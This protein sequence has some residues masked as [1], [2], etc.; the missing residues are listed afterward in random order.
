MFSLVLGLAAVVGYGSRSVAQLPTIEPTL[1]EAPETT[2]GLPE[3]T[4]ESPPTVPETSTTS[5]ELPVPASP[6]LPAPGSP[7]LP[8][9]AYL[10][11][12]GDTIRIDILG[13][14][15][16]SGDY[17]IPIDGRLILPLVGSISV[18]GLT[19]EEAADAISKAY[20]NILK[21]P[22]ISVNL[23]A[24]RPL[25]IWIAGEINRPGSYAVSLIGG[26]G[27]R[28][29]TQYPTVTQVIEQAGGIKLTADLRRIELRRPQ[30]DGSQRTININLWEMLQTGDPRRGDI[31]LL[32]GDSIFIPTA[33]TVNLAE[34]RQLANTS[35]A[36]PIDQARNVTV[37]GEVARPGPYIVLGG[38][39]GADFNVGGLPTVT[40]AIQIA[41]GIKP[42]ANLREIQLRRPTRGGATEIISVNLWQ[43]LQTGDIN[44]DPIVQDGDII[45]VPATTEVNP[46]EA[47][48]IATASFAPDTIE[49]T[50]VGE[51][52][53]PGRIRVPPNSPL[54]QALSV[55]GGFR[56]DRAKQDSVELVRF[57][58]DG[59]VAQQ[60][61]PVDLAA[62]I[63]SQSNPMLRNNDIVVVNPSG[64]VKFNNS[65]NNAL[66]FTDNTNRLLT[67]LGFL[68]ILQYLQ[69]P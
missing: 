30:R 9:S 67:V 21:R 11:G 17:Q 27:Q 36:I 28:P 61:I 50:V 48:Q 66:N 42:L 68:G 47:E 37:V 51:V 6:E 33:T 41:G 12:G 29:G 3:S 40:R 22:V 55:A 2:P 19:L 7:E 46:A 14:Q 60:M 38:D 53:N 8:A 57:N 43:L 52:M 45:V 62:G 49:V 31:T 20:A 4:P 16:Y 64:I 39:T 23:Q 34:I 59:T 69:I 44:Q 65:F 18:Q 54:N 13:V 15:Q 1:P 58:S 32:D 63:N 25:N 35:F 10:L 5:P 26:V 24:P 56:L